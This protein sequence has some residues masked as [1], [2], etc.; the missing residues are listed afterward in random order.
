MS[1]ISLHFGFGIELHGIKAH[2]PI[3]IESQL[4]LVCNRMHGSF[5]SAHPSVMTPSFFDR[6]CNKTFS[7]KVSDF[8]LNLILLSC[9]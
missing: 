9:F 5:V 1:P 3:C 8:I 4:A 2:C 6:I 7:D